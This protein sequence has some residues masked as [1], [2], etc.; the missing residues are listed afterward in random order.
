M[1]LRGKTLFTNG[2]RNW[3]KEALEKSDREE[4]RLIFSNFS[5][6]DEGKS[7]QLVCQLNAAHHE[8]EKNRVLIECAPDLKKVLIQ[9]LEAHQEGGRYHEI[10]I[11]NQSAAELLKRLGVEDYIISSLVSQ[12]AR[13]HAAEASKLAVVHYVCGNFLNF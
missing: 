8:F 11:A 12:N 5:A 7:R 2:T 6:S 1:W 13:V 4:G 10:K 9:V 3:S